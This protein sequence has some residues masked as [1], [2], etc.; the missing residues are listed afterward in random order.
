MLEKEGGSYKKRESVWWEAQA[1]QCNAMVVVG[2][3]FWCSDA[4]IRNG[5]F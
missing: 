2:C 1:K 5:V 3:G 4:E